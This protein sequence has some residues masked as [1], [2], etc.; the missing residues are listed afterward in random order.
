V[1]SAVIAEMLGKPIAEVGTYRPRAPF[2]P[3]TVGALA[4]L[5]TDPAAGD[6]PVSDRRRGT[7]S[8]FEGT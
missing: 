6:R 2:K 8:R 7:P 3:I 1:V 5:D 4:D